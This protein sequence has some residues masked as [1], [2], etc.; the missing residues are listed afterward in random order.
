MNF[1]IFLAFSISPKCPGDMVKVPNQ[2][3]CIDKYEWPNIKG[4]NPSLGLTA[5]A[6]KFDKEKGVIMDAESLCAS[7]GKRMCKYEEW[8][9]SCKGENK[10]DFP[11]GSSLPEW[12]EDQ[13][14]IPCNFWRP[15]IKPDE[16]KVWLRD[17]D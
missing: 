11:F 9:P 15:F 5:V 2:D 8:I 14:K 1:L 12:N 17:P 7:V 4:K 3:S 13:D 6:S 16:Y 10:S